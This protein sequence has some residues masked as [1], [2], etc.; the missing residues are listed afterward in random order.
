MQLVAEVQRELQVLVGERVGRW[1]DER[2]DQRMD[3]L[4]QLR[5]QVLGD[6]AARFGK[7]EHAAPVPRPGSQHARAPAAAHLPCGL[8]YHHSHLQF[9]E[10]IST[11]AASSARVS[12][13]DRARRAR[14]NLSGSRPDGALSADPVSRARPEPEGD[15]HRLSVAHALT[16]GGRAL[17]LVGVHR[18]RQRGDVLLALRTLARWRPVSG[19]RGE[20]P[21]ARQDTSGDLVLAPCARD[22]RQPVQRPARRPQLTGRPRQSAALRRGSP[23]EAMSPAWRA[24]RAEV[25]Q[26][27]RAAGAVADRARQLQARSQS[28]VPRSRSPQ[29]AAM[30]PALRMTEASTEPCRV[31]EDLDGFVEAA[32][33]P[34]ESPPNQSAPASTC[35]A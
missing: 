28:T 3:G 10:L 6:L 13:S 33:G 4:R 18:S 14:T 20:P 29:S 8:P 5:E 19:L 7:D 35:S 24:D 27:L 1:H 34:L 30:S 32:P 2:R 17:E 9:E 21:G 16:L 15:V 25:V 23:A 12:A 11:S 22:A 31:V 26:R